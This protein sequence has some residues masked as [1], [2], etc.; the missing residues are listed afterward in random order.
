MARVTWREW[1]G[2][3]AGLLAVGTLFLP[4]TV[5]AIDTTD[6]DVQNAFRALPEGDVVRSAWHA[7]PF[8]WLPPLV[9]VLIGLAVV[10]FGQV[11]KVRMSGLPQLWLV[12]GL[13]T[14]LL[15][16]IGWATLD[17]VFDSDQ[18]AFLEAAGVTVGAGFGRYLGLLFALVSTVAAVF[19]IRAA[20][21]E[22]RASRR[23][24]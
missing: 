4:W 19:D 13:A 18:R 20:R 5:L 1:L 11:R 8:S 10:G 12:A 16:V 21:A 14:V 7:D 22:S 15:M 24:R 9:L 2:L 3:A 23:R 6:P 17:W